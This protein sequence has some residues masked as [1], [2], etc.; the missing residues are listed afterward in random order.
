MID[1]KSLGKDKKWDELESDYYS[2]AGIDKSMDVQPDISDNQLFKYQSQ[3]KNKSD[4]H[5]DQTRVKKQPPRAID[6]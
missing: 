2:A 1:G 4:H 5:K 3:G 6:Q